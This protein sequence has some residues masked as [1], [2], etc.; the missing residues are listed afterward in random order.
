MKR[1]TKQSKGKLKLRSER[2][3]L[4]SSDIPREQLEAV[5]GGYFDDAATCAS[6]RRCGNTA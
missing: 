6:C 5:R 4:L 1:D 3:R 2:I